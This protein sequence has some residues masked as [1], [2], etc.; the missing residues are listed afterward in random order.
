M[1]P[2][3]DVGGELQGKVALVTGASGGIGGAIARQLAAAGADLLLH[4]NRRPAVAHQLRDELDSQGCAASVVTADL[5]VAEQRQTLI[6]QAWSW[7]QRIDVCVNNAGADVLTG[8]VAD[9]TFEARLAR[10]WRVDVLGTIDLSRTLGARMVERA[11][12]DSDRA[13]L[14]IGWDQAAQGMPGESGE[15]FA[16]I[17]GA[18][19]A[20]SRSLAGSLAPHVRVN[21]LAPGW[22]KTAWGE[23]T[24]AY[25]QQRAAAESLLGRW[26]TP[27]DV[28][29]VARFLVSPAAGFIT[30][31]V[32]PVNGGFRY[33]QLEGLAPSE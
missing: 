21:C 18:V 16:T 4:A 2:R 25:W 8:A 11:A 27:A 5:A 9:E 32:V 19:M 22:V 28:A 1:S 12:D 3:A 6:E 23:S 17:K 15:M 14:N 26:G 30:G 13:I 10:L 33:G 31:Q 24:S 7:R 20:F 29:R